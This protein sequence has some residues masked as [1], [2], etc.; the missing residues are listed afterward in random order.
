M[1]EPERTFCADLSR[2]NA[3]PLAATASRV[4]HWILV[5]YRGLWGRDALAGSGLSDQVKEHLRGPGDA[6]CRT[7]G[8]CS[9]G[10]RTGAGRPSSSC[11]RPL[12]AGAT[13]ALTRPRSRRTTTCST[14]TSWAE[15]RRAIRSS[16]SARTA[17]T[18]G[19]ARAT[20]GRS[21]RRSRTSSSTTGSGRSSHVGGDRF[22][23]NLVC[24]P[25]GLYLRA[26]R[27]RDG[28]VG[29]RRVS[30]RRIHIGELP[31]DGRS[32]AFAVQAAE[33]AVRELTGLVGIDD[34]VLE[35]VE[36]GNGSIRVVFAAGGRTHEV[37]VDY[38]PGDLT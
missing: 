31:R 3:E 14:S 6:R 9:S 36:P 18:T 34:L 25:E 13:T 35:R 1:T 21:T 12:R 23:G 17:S 5:E 29:A 15:S 22:A 24:L 26:G 38:E 8:S 19:A 37:R 2:E 30:R 33:R 11:S 16:S 20:G 4:D 7:A 27:P 28:R 10:A 32:T